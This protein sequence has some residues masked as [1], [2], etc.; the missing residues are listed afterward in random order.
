MKVFFTSIMLLLLL[1]TSV[2]AQ[3]AQTEILLLGCDHFQQIYKKDNPKLDCTPKV[4]RV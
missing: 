4:G 3:S 2:F 1:F